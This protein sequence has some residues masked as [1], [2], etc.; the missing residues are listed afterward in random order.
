MPAGRPSSYTTEIADFLCMRI[1]DGES[2]RKICFDEDMPSQS[3]VFRWLA[4]NEEFREKYARAREAQMEVMALEIV[5]IADDSA[6]DTIITDDGEK[7]NNEWIQRSRLRVETRKWLMSKL[8]P[9]VYGERPL[10]GESPENP[11]HL[12]VDRDELMA[13]LIGKPL[14]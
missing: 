14:E 3:M 1:A 2:L 11:L 13:K 7:P 12:K 10:P 5:E 9:K 6:K 4:S 8:R